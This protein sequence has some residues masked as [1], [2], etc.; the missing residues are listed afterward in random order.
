M[1]LLVDLFSIF[2]AVGTN[3]SS[4]AGDMVVAVPATAVIVAVVTVGVVAAVVALVTLAACNLL[5]LP[6]FAS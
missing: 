6:S 3:D 4:G 2:A 1:Q 5:C